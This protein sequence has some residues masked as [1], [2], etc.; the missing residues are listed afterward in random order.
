MITT[1]SPVTSIAQNAKISFTVLRFNGLHKF[2]HPYIFGNLIVL[3]ENI[4]QK[5]PN[6]RVSP[7]R[8]VL[9]V[10]WGGELFI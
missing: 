10:I 4:H 7:P 1:Y 6:C 3:N 8:G 9:L 2:L 5:F